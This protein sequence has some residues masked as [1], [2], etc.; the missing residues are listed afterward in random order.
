M[1]K[2]MLLPLA[3][4][5]SIA[6][7]SLLVPHNAYAASP[8]QIKVDKIDHV[9]TPIYGGLLLIN[10]T[11]RI[12]SPADNTRIEN[13]SIGFPLK[14]RPNLRFSMAYEVSAPNEQLNVILDTGLGTTGY[15][16]VTVVFPNGGV[17]LNK[18]QTYT[19]TVV[20]V[21]SD[22]IDSLVNGATQYVFTADFPLYPSLVQNAE[23]CN[24]TIILPKNTE[25][26][27]TDFIFN[28][29]Y[30]EGRYYLN[31]TKSP[32]QNLTRESLEL[33]FAS[34]D[35]DSFAC[36]TVNRLNREVTIDTNQGVLVSD[37]FLL[38]SKTAF[39]VN[40]IK[41]QLPTD[42]S[43]V[44]AFDELERTITITRRE[45]GITTHEF[46]LNLT[47][48]QSRSFRV[49]YMLSGED[50]LA[51]KD[52]QN[53]EVNLSL[54]ENLEMMPNTFAVKVIFPEGA[55]IQSFPQQ[56]FNI[57]RDVFQEKLSLS[58]SNIT[59][60]QNE[61]WTI[62]YRH[63]IFWN[64]FRPT[65]WTT[66]IVLIGAVIAFAWQR[67]KPPTPVSAILVPRKTLDA[68]VDT[69]EEKKKTLAELEQIKR[70]ARKGKV[71][72]RRYKVRRT[73]LENRLATLTNKLAD[74]RQK[75]MS[76]GAKYADIM[77]QLEVSETELDNI[78]ADVTRIEVR[79]KRGEISA[80]TYRRLLEDDLRRKEKA[81]TTIDGL[82]LRLRE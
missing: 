77:R 71:S 31:Y 1:K 20:F 30:K 75:I 21:L 44:S 2:A 51:G 37:T 69:Y 19:F 36:F 14:Y 27:P 43:N 8:S 32:L 59:W 34:E 28:A 55:V 10:D 49:V 72:R 79:F 53:Y 64:A 76:G 67:P 73:T 38:E 40:K 82:L 23:T 16:G 24:V 42:A 65:L 13:F 50:R 18:D 17:T 61:Q 25:Y 45:N 11:I 12:S 5:F 22:S 62:I 57:Q 63:S 46:S 29:T 39:A 3:L 4:I 47:K 48:Y 26:S 80:E 66:V 56:T 6:S 35:V 54:F 9:V 58:F 7:I 78:K 74:L 15:Y 68:F 81:T 52:S 70:K 41:L 33:S 60:L